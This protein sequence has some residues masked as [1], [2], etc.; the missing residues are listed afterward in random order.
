MNKIQLHNFFQEAV[1]TGVTL[2]LMTIVFATFSTLLFAY[3]MG[4]SGSI[5]IPFIT[6][7]AVVILPLVLFGNGERRRY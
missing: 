6:M 2:L 7:T 4:E 5:I 3:G 1:T